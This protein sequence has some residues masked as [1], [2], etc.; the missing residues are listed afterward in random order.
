MSGILVLIHEFNGMGS[1]MGS[2]FYRYSQNN[3]D[4]RHTQ[5]ITIYAMVEN[6][7]N[8]SDII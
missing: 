7:I 8:K 6:K 2:V 4:N 1:T 5:S 3:M